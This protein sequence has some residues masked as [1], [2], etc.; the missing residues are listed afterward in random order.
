MGGFFGKNM[1]I[2]G[3]E[4]LC[5]LP[6]I[7]AAGYMARGV[8]V[9]IFGA[10]ALVLLLREL[11][12]T[13]GSLGQSSSLSRLAASLSPGQAKSHLRQALQAA[14]VA[15][16]GLALLV[17]LFKSP[18]ADLLGMPDG[19]AMYLPLGL[20][21][22][23]A[24]LAEVLLD[25]YFKARENVL[26]QGLFVIARSSIEVAAVLLAFSGAFVSVADAPLDAVA[27]YV[28]V[29]FAL[30]L[31]AYP[32]LTLIGAPPRQP[33]SD[34]QRRQFSRYGLPMVPAALVAVLVAQGDRLV[35]GRL[36]EVGEL[37]VY[38][39]AAGLAAYVAYL[40]YAVY[41]LLLPR[42]STL[43]DAGD[44][45]GVRHLFARC[46]EVFVV[47]FLAAMV[48]VVLFAQDI[49]MLTAG[50]A[51]A[52]AAPVLVVLSLAVGL[53][54]LFGVYQW[55]F[56]LVKKPR[57]FVYLGLLN[58]L[59]V[60]SAVAGFFTVGGLPL[61]PWA[62]VGAVLIINLTRFVLAR[63]HLALGFPIRLLIIL[64]V[65]MAGV[66]ALS[67][68]ATSWGLL[69]RG[70]IVAGCGVVALA[71]VARLIGGERA[72]LPTPGRKAA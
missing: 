52:A 21:L 18:I 38:A 23:V 72:V 53:E 32:A 22:V 49:I 59:L 12:V 26:R 34:E 16:A 62:H 28:T 19:S 65:G 47:M 68:A 13:L 64:I 10:W 6:M 42:A 56:H 33:L 61:V 14:A 46:Q 50:P 43:Y 63:R 7:F 66:F 4:I 24:G 2:G 3:V 27:L 41:P 9:E 35:L 37:G 29:G 67:Q 48:G 69:P 36:A 20:V 57:M 30:K 58:L 51:F 8:G 25:A 70:L 55:T 11:L 31:L 40:G 1:M 44:I 54:Q 45:A 17:W 15:F 5:R 71:V 39:F 60:F